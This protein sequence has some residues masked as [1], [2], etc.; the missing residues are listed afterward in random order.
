[1]TG[2]PRIQMTGAVK[3]ARWSSPE[4][5]VGLI[6]EYLEDTLIDN[7]IGNNYVETFIGEERRDRSL[8]GFSTRTTAGD[9]IV[10]SHCEI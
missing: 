5:P 4:T 2:I 8:R 10:D 1:M 3:W 6:L 7:V 9:I